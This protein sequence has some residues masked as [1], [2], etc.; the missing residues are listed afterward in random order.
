MNRAMLSEQ[1]KRVRVCRRHNSMEPMKVCMLFSNTYNSTQE[2][3][4]MVCRLNR[5][6]VSARRKARRRR[7][8]ILR[9]CVLKL[10]CSLARQHGAATFIHICGNVGVNTQNGRIRHHQPV[11][12]RKHLRGH[13]EHLTAYVHGLM[14]LERC[15]HKL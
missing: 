4:A 9:R 10:R 14:R 13:N 3:T 5:R 6:L 1:S 8:D 15:N 12:E 11:E 7:A 2:K